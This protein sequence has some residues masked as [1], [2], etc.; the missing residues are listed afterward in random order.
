MKHFVFKIFST[1]MLTGFSGNQNKEKAKVCKE[2]KTPLNRHLT[3][4]KY[5]SS[6]DNS[7]KWDSESARHSLSFTTKVKHFQTIL[8]MHPS[9]CFLQFCLYST[10]N[11]L[12]IGTGYK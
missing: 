2:P 10:E 4:M 6:M 5:M 8:L 7:D 1:C 3:E 12:S 11:C 9:L